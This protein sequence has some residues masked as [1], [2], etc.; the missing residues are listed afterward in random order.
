MKKGEKGMKM[1]NEDIMD[2]VERFGSVTTYTFMV[3]GAYTVKDNSIIN[4]GLTMTLLDEGFDTARYMQSIR[5]ITLDDEESWP[6]GWN[7]QWIFPGDFE[8]EFIPLLISDGL[9]HLRLPH[10]YVGVFGSDMGA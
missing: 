8:Y 1:F 3:Y 6:R 7:L 4:K 5:E 2:W 9:D 10:E